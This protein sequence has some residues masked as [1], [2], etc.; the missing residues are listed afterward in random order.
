[1]RERYEKPA[2]ESESVFESLAA[3]CTFISALDDPNCDPDIKPT[4]QELNS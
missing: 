3:G 2:C 4:F 1:V